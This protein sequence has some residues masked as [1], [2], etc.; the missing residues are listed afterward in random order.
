MDLVT[1]G[2]SAIRG[3]SPEQMRA[4][5]LI[6]TSWWGLPDAQHPRPQ[7]R[8]PARSARGAAPGARHR[9]RHP[10][11]DLRVGPGRARRR[12]DPAAR[13]RARSTPST[14]RRS[15]TMPRRSRRSASSR[16]TRPEE[17]IAELDHATG[18]LGLKAFMFGGPDQ[19][20][21]AGRRP[22]VARGALARLAR[23]RLDLRLRP[24]VA[25]V[26][27]ARRVADVP[28]RGDGLDGPR[29]GEQLRVQPHRHVRHRRRAHGAVVV[30]GRRARSGSRRCG[31]RSRRAAS[32]GPPRCYANLVG[33]WEKRNRD[34]VEH[35]NPAHL[36]RAQVAAA[37]R[38][39]RVEALPRAARPARRR[40]AHAEPPRRGS[41]PRSTSSPGAGSRASTTSATCS[42][43]RSTSGARPTTR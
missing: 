32:R 8:A 18:E 20:S 41:R 1:S 2:G 40:P 15:A 21:G 27:R 29:V 14:R 4:A 23:A 34:A 33:H 25:A 31:S 36:D 6:R 22:A 5:G 39:V 28:H 9:P 17:A 35:Y 26:R 19:P 12:R 43:P 13:W 42:P 10:V 11:P 24:G 30:H 16:C 38:G 7:H 37:V 3:L